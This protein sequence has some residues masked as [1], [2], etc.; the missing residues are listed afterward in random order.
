MIKCAHNQLIDIFIKLNFS[1]LSGPAVE[2]GN[3][4]YF[5]EP[6]N[7]GSVKISFIAV[8]MYDLN[9]VI[10]DELFDCKYGFDIKGVVGINRSP[11]CGVETTSKDNQ[12]VSGEGVF[13][14]ALCKELKKEKISVKIAGIK[15]SNPEEAVKAVQ[16]LIGG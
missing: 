16:K 9:G 10:D 8:G 2:R 5:C 6:A 1:I 13:I 14:E 7:A 4:G 3:N 15:A 11:S 12:E